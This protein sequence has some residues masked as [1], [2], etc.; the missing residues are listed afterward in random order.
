MKCVMAYLVEKPLIAQLDEL[1]TYAD[2]E[3]CVFVDKA[4]GKNFDRPQYETLFDR[5]REGDV[6][7]IKSLDRLGRNYKEIK[8][9]WHTLTVDV[10]VKIN[11]LDMPLLSEMQSDDTMRKLISNIVFDLLA[12][13]AENER[14]TLLQRQAEGITAAKK[15]GK[16]FGRPSIPMPSNFGELYEK[17]QRQE[18][19]AVSAMREM[20]LRPNTFY[21]MA[22][23]YRLQKGSDNKI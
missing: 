10:G 1:I 13:I 19:T 15:R 11:V 18:I 9:E 3:D 4:S 7:T 14:T 2:N 16:K 23:K 6:L 20:G 17:V 8:E 21:A 12:F 22:K 5:L